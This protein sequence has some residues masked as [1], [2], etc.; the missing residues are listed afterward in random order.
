MSKSLFLKIIVYLFSFFLAFG[1]FDPFGTN[2]V[3]F[4]A[5]TVLLGMSILLSTDAFLYI[6]KY[7]IQLSILFAIGIIMFIMGFIYGEPYFNAKYFSAVIIFWLLSYYYISNQIVCFNSIFLFAISSALIALLYNFGFLDSYFNI[8]TKGRLQLFEENPNS[9]S[10]RMAIAFVSLFYIVIENPLKYKKIRFLLLLLLPSLFFIVIAFASRG[11]SLLLI[12][13]SASIILLSKI[14][15][16]YKLFLISG[17]FLLYISL[18]GF[19]KT[20]SLFERFEQEENVLGIRETIW[21]NAFQIFYDNPNGIGELGYVKEMYSRYNWYLD[22]HN[23]Y[24]Y[25]LVTGGIFTLLLFLL[26]LAQLFIKSY[27]N[28]RRGNSFS[29][30]LLIFLLF[31]AGKTGGILTYLVMWFFFSIIYSFDI[32]KLNDE[33]N[34]SPRLGSS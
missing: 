17:A 18:I 29:V 19:F 32:K 14:S 7:S 31:L 2:G 25:F 30:I 26:F 15:K 1:K 22:T 16:R 24:L 4:D 33:L 5:I 12:M 10:T 27:T 11:S 20:T 9:I 28:L 8:D 21:E 13:G 6:K 23:L 34:S 3:F